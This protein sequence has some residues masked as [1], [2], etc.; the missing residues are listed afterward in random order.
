VQTT[1]STPP[2]TFTL[3]VTGTSGALS[4]QSTVSLTVR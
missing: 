4:H 1:G 2:G 3:R